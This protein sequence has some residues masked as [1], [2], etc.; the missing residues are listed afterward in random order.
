MV[1]GLRTKNRKGTSIQ[2]DYLVHIQEIKPWPPSQSLKSLR[3]VLLQWENG[4]RNIGSTSPAV[5]SLGSGVGDGKIEFNESFKLP[6]TLS[7]AVSVK[8]GDVDIFLKNCLEFNLYEP[9]RD[10]TVKGQLMGTVII[11]LADYGIVNEPISISAPMNCKRSFRNTAQP[12]LFVKI[13]PFDKDSSSSLS[14]ENLSKETSL[15]KDGRESVSALI[16]GEYAEESEIASFTDDDVSSHSSL[17]ISSSVFEAS[18]GSP[19]QN[20]EGISYGTDQMWA[21]A[22]TFACTSYA[23]VAIELQNGSEAV[24]DST[25][26]GGREPA[27]PSDPVPTKSEVE[28]VSVA[29]KHLNGSSPHSSSIDRSS[30]LGGPVNDHSSLSNFLERSLLSIPKQ[31]VTRSVQSSSSSIAYEGIEEQSNNSMGR[32]DRDY[33]AQEVHEKVANGRNKIKDSAQEPIQEIITDNISAKVASS[34]AGLQENEKQDYASS[35]AS[36]V[37]GEDDGK[38]WRQ[39]RN[40]P[41]AAATNHGFKPGLMEDENREKQEENGQDEQIMEERR[42]STEDDQLD[43]F[44]RDSSRKQVLS[45]S[46][47]VIFSRGTLGMKGDISSSDGL[48]HVKSVRSPLDLAKNN[49]SIS[50]DQ[51]MEEVQEINV[52]EY[53]HNGARNFSTNERK[54]AKVVS[55]G[56]RNKFSDNKVQQLERK[57]E[58]LEGELREAAAVEVGLYSIVAEHGSST[59]KVHAPARRLSRLYFHAYKERSQTR[60]ASAARSTVS[61]L[62]LVAK[63]CGNDVPR[64]TFW[65]SNSVVLRTIISQAIGDQL[66]LSAGPCIETNDGRKGNDSSS[67]LLKW[68]EYSPSKKEKIRVTENFDNWEDP[69]TF[70]TALEKIEAWI[71]SRIIESVWWQTLTPHMQSVAGKPSNRSMGSSSRKTYGRKYNLGDQEQGDFSLDLWKKAFKDSCERLCPIRAGGHE[72]GCL[73]VLARLVCLYVLFFYDCA[74]V[75]EQCVRRLDVAMFNA[76]LRESDDEIPTDPVSDPI[77]D[78]KV[79]P[80]PAG[81]SSFGAGAQLK[82]A[83]G[84]WSRWLT[85]LFGIDDDSSPKDENGL[86][87]EDIQEFESSLKP[88]HLLNALS[89]LMMLPKDMLLNG[90]IRKE[91]CPAFGALLIKRVLNNFVPDEF[92]PDPIPEVVL[93]ALDSEDPLETEEETI[94]N[95]PCNATPTVYSPPSAASLAGFIGEVGSQSQLRRSRSSVLRKSYTSDDELEELDSPLSSI[96][97]DSIRASPTS[98][99]PNWMPRGNSGRNAVRYQ[100]L[101]EVWRDGN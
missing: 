57:I 98:T 58:M 45:G 67:S 29:Y 73:P 2:V 72:C 51:I 96:I 99:I 87:N 56:I 81:K 53:G 40:G 93:Q 37:N 92:C 38:A 35:A 27:L 71:F 47:S 39:S 97:I 26:S 4:D 30:D 86:E 17:T 18:A 6:V 36:H 28:P 101:R 33:L 82:N 66:P 42:H 50:D 3:S 90:S 95:F 85:D 75:M 77:S 9:R 11:D 43:K 83:I 91:V 13:Q 22:C 21:P 34:N 88:F 20:D 65:L 41:D 31:S 23:V 24:K 78:S 54:D 19:P 76:I 55:R 94:T 79:L 5:P 70:T 89:D 44:S 68:K 25:A 52:L 10:K 100:L 15:D 59:N 48:K 80:I 32:F 60:R 84:N 14:R 1:L 8:G 63:A 49:G 64:L 12:V 74:Q 69:H 16:N 7:K 61:G 46:H 62:V